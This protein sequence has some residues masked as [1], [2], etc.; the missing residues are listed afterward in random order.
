VKRN[1]LVYYTEV[2]KRETTSRTSGKL[3]ND[4]YVPI[5]TASTEN[6]QCTSRVL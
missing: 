5:F 2:Y 3:S 4:G 1:A 6:L